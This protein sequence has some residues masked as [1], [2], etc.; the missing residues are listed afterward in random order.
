VGFLGRF[1]G[2]KQDEDEAPAPPAV[3]RLTRVRD[4]V[5]TLERVAILVRKTVTDPAA[6]P[7]TPPETADP[8]RPS[9]PPVVLARKP[10]ERT[11]DWSRDRSWFGGLPRLGGAAWPC[12]PDG[13]P[14]PFAAQIDL[15]EVAAACPESPLPHEGSLA[16]FV[17]EGA[18]IHVP[19]GDHA[20]SEPPEGLP[21]AYDEGSH[22]LPERVSHTTRPL[23]PFWPVA[24][25]GLTLPE[26]LRSHTDEE[27]HDE[28]REAQ[29]AL[30]KNRLQSR[31]TAFSVYSARGEAI[32]GADD[33]WWFGVQHLV[34]GLRNAVDDAPR[35]IAMSAEAGDQAAVAE[36]ER[37]ARELPTF[38]AA[39]ENLVAGRDPWVMLDD[40]ELD[41]VRQA[42]R[43]LRNE[44]ADLVCHHIPHSS[45]ELADLCIRR[46][47]TGDDTA[48]AALPDAMLAFINER[49]RLTSRDP[50]QM[51]G[52]AGVRQ[53]NLY[54]H[55]DDLLLLQMGYD[56]LN[57]WRF[58]D[59]GLWH[60]WISPDA[61][62]A[63][64]W[65]KATLTFESA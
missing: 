40:E 46:M 19:D 41:I 51:F 33:L 48:L 9:P 32:E 28:I 61:V 26:A 45:D 42:L 62:A 5:E 65:D 27:Q 52:L 24:S 23:F 47:I 38:V 49:Y 56:D 16:F 55:L 36:R 8:A 22:P 13:T 29:I 37:Q 1:L 7:L 6:R 15:A 3:E 14:L 2:S 4:R 44:F 60:F 57:E 31:D 35:L 10:R 21:H 39:L 64:R 25:I 43:A 50:H 53:G 59:M 11:R 17:G 12:G 58:G 20:P 34:A 63:G 54:D 18:V 30:L